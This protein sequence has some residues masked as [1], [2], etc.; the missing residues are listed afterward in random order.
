MNTATRTA[1]AASIAFLIG[2]SAASAAET[3]H[4]Y[5][6]GG[7]LPAMREAAA[8]FGKT[9]GVDVQVTAGAAPQWLSQAKQD[10]GLVV[11]GSEVMMSDF[12]AAMP[13]QIDPATIAP[14]YL[15]PSA[16]LVRPGNPR[17]VA[18]IGDL[19][20]PGNRI[21]VVNVAGQQ[22]LWED[23]AGRWAIWRA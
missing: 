11:S 21:L 7:P 1:A 3:L 20:Q 23:V 17:H 2:S 6:P 19:L 18:G 8:T 15:R 22:G 12:I 5:G 16:G 14:L 9:A 10:A 13:D 4:A